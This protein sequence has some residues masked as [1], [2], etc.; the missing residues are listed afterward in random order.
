MIVEEVREDFLFDEETRV[1]PA[2]LPRRFRQCEADFRQPDQP[3]VFFHFLLAAS[4][5][6]ISCSVTCGSRPSV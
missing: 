2:S 4:I 5:N 6:T 1:A 3:F